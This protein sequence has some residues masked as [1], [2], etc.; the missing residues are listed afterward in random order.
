MTQIIRDWFEGVRWLDPATGGDRPVAVAIAAESPTAAPR[1]IPDPDPTLRP[2]TPQ[3]GSHLILGP[4]LVDAYSRSGEPGFES[5]ETLAQY[6]AAAA[7]GGFGRTALLPVGQP[8]ADTVAALRDRRDRLAALAQPGHPQVALWAAL[9]LNRDG[10]QL[11]ELADLAA[12]GAIGF[13]DNRPIADPTLLQHLL[14]YAQIL[15][16]PIALWPRNSTWAGE[17]VVL[18]GPLALRLGLPSYPA[19]AESSAVATLLEVVATVP[20]PVHLMR[21][22]TARSVHLIRQAKAAGLP[23]TASTTWLHLLRD[24]SHLAE[25]Q[26]SSGWPYDPNLRLDPPL[27]NPSDRTALITALAEGTLDAIAIDHTPYTYEEKTVPFGQAPPGA[28]GLEIALPLLWH[29]LVIPGHCPALR[30]W[31]ALSAAPARCLHW[32]D[33]PE[34]SPWILFDPTQTWIAGPGTLRSPA[35]NT[36]WLGHPIPGQVCQC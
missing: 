21:I 29:H 5:R 19:A 1:L 4:A 17:G 26:R 3:D 24:A 13:T 7:A 11:A 35:H 6:L 2:A 12:A 14:D 31:D 28:I 23:I 33:A 34:P 8:P 16:R 10:K 20:T 15:Q 32:P 27:G 36:P 30:L 22:A 25:S 18:D 9:T